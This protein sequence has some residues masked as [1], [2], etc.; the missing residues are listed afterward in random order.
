[1]R[2]AIV[3]KIRQEAAT[4]AEAARS[5]HAAATHEENKARSKYETLALEASYIAQGQANRAQELR[6]ALRRYELL[7]LLPFAEGSPIEVTA[8]VTYEDSAGLRRVVFLG[9]EQG[10]L[11][12]Q[13]DGTE[14][15][16]ITGSSPLAQA[17]LGQTLDDEFTFRGKECH[18][19]GVM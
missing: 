11:R 4:L 19:T 3:E 10:G 16:V 6:D 14:V 18:I 17:L 7:E 5:A 2:E 1:M 9:P 12:V 15:V 8:L 13:V